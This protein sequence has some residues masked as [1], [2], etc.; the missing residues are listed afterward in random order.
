MKTGQNKIKMIEFMSS[1]PISRIFGAITLIIAVL[2]HLE[3]FDILSFYFNKDFIFQNHEYWRLITSVLCFG[4]MGYSTFMQL[5]G[6]MQYTT[7]SEASYFDTR[8][9]DFLLFSLF[10]IVSLWAYACVRPALFLGP[11][12]TSYYLYY[13][14]KRAPDNR[15]MLLIFPIPLPAP[16]IPLVL[17]ALHITEGDFI[18]SVSMSAYAYLIAHIY[19]FLH[20][21]ISLRFNINLLTCPQWMNNA[22]YKIVK[23]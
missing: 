14:A 4:S 22:L 5:V 10:G 11:G 17:L 16:Y 7:T 13:S 21:I 12:L 2:L 18:N 20:D 1:S 19:F 9:A 3:K 23:F 8:P 15:L 6:F